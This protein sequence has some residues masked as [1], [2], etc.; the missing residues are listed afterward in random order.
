[1]RRS[2]LDLPRL[3]WEMTRLAIPHSHSFSS[4][5]PGTPAIRCHAGADVGNQISPICARGSP[6]DIAVDGL[7]MLPVRLP[8][9]TGLS[10]G[11]LGDGLNLSLHRSWSHSLF[12]AGTA[13]IISIDSAMDLRG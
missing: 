13:P 3:C 4:G 8:N 6:H 2:R 7:K 5:A 11:F 12:M 10:S 9:A 1:M